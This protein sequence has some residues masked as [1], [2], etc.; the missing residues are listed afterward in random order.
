MAS[1]P[2][3]KILIS[4]VGTND[5]GKLDGKPEGAILTALHALPKFDEI[6]LLWSPTGNFKNI[7][8]HLECEI[9][10]NSFSKAVKLV[11]FDLDD[12][13]DHNEIYPKLLDFCRNNLNENSDNIA[14]IS[15][16]TPAMQVCWILLAESGDFR[17]RLI[18][19]NEPKHNKTPYTEIKLGT[20]LPEIVKRVESENKNLKELLPEVKMNIS[21]GELKIG[22]NL[23]KLSPIQFAYYR[24]FLARA[25][26]GKGFER[27]PMNRTHLE[28]VKKI[29]EYHNDSFPESDQEILPTVKLLK[30][31]D[32]IAMG[33]FRPVLSKINGKIVVTINSK[34]IARYYLIESVGTRQALSYGISLPKQ[35]INIFQNCCNIAKII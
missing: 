22:N 35:K 24:Y 6:I 16:G 8:K 9:I 12:P 26:D 34:K 11:P 13:T 28:F 27:F 1:K 5:A 4:F 17:L 2:K 31:R 14:A 20:G 23:I 18:K 29:I 10:G 30:N 32:G 33:N 15:S 21:K 7:S 19:S 3:P 25:K